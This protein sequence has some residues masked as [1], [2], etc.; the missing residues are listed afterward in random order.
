MGY[1]FQYIIHSYMDVAHIT[2][3][4]GHRV[5]Q[6]EEMEINF[7]MVETSASPN[8]KYLSPTQR[9]CRFENEPL[10]MDMP[11]YSTSMCYM[12]CRYKRA[13]KFCGCKPFHYHFLGEW[14]VIGFC[15]HLSLH[16]FLFLFKHLRIIQKL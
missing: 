15:D 12:L 1:L 6:S 16:Q 13:L 10:S 11:M 14:V 4:Q 5:Q 2:S 3:K 7:K 8:I 9:R